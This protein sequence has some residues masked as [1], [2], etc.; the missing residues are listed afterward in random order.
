[1]VLTAAILVVLANAAT[2]ARVMLAP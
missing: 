1:M 2:L